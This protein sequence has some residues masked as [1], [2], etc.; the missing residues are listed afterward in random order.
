VYKLPADLTN[1]VG[2]ASGYGHALALRADGSVRGW[3]Y[4]LYGECDPP[5]DLTNAI[6]VAACYNNSMA[7][8]AD[9]AVCVW[10]ESGTNVPPD[11]TNV[12]TIAA[13]NYHYMALLA[14][15]GLRV[16]GANDNGQT[17]VPVDLVNVRRIFAGDYHCLALV[18]PGTGPIPPPSLLGPPV[19]N[20]QTAPI[21]ASAFFSIKADG[22]PPFS[23]QWFF[24]STNALAG[25]TNKTLALHGLVTE[26]T[27]NYSVVVS[28]YGGSTTSTPSV[29][30]VVPVIS[31][32]MVPALELVGEVGRQYRVDYI[33]AVGP[34]DAWQLLL[35][36]TLT[37]N[38][39]TYFDISAKGKPARYY[40]LIQLP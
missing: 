35:T 33:N 37:N 25:A 34:T 18:D 12:V 2:L 11:I 1:I 17:N 6:A 32:S 4:N 36:L 21:G 16:W 14:D 28:N 13:G 7:M 40:R 27:G 38:P 19:P 9:G 22:T 20:S 29:L 23:Y 31:V 39:E 8:K 10:G 15:G 30:A 26:Q 5:G 24:N 3:G